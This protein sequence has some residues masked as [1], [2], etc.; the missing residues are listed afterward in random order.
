MVHIV[1]YVRWEEIKQWNGMSNFIVRKRK[2]TEVSDDMEINRR[3]RR[4]RG[5]G[6]GGPR[7]SVHDGV[8]KAM[9]NRGLEFGNSSVSTD[10]VGVREPEKMEASVI[11]RIGLGP[12]PGLNLGF[13]GKQE[14]QWNVEG[15]WENLEKTPQES[16]LCVPQM[17]SAISGFRTCIHSNRKPVLCQRTTKTANAG[18]IVGIASSINIT[19]KPRSY[20][21]RSKNLDV[22]EEVHCIADGGSNRRIDIIVI[23]RNKQ[24]AEI[25]DPTIRFEISTT[26]PSEV[27]EEKKKIYEPMIQYLSAKYNIEKNH[28]YRSLLRSERHHPESLCKVEG[29]IQADERSSRCHRHHHW[30]SYLKSRMY[31]DEPRNTEDLKRRVRC[32]SYNCEKDNGVFRDR[33]GYCLAVNGSR[34]ATSVIKFDW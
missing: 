9:E 1:N 19:A 27:N 28:S 12:W 20:A 24:T 16:W 23:N 14:L 13:T 34:F 21:L 32:T 26:Q 31:Q 6:R 8:I 3:R 22:H 15:K 10:I 29:K 11:N 5:R 7:K 17:D 4:R 25:I 2:I 33:L 30:V 18:R